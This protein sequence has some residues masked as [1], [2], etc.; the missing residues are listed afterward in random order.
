MFL[1]PR[2][3]RKPQRHQWLERLTLAKALATGGHL[4]KAARTR[5]AKIVE[6]K[7]KQYSTTTM[8][9]QQIYT[10]LRADALNHNK[11]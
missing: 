1:L 7:V 4:W 2:D 3:R 5:S 6:S 10:Q 11:N 9:A 8:T